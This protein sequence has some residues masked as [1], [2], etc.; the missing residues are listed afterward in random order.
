MEIKK[1]MQ[2]MYQKNV[3]KKKHF[4][5]LLM[6]EERK[7]HYVLVKDF[8]IFMYDYTLH[9]GIKDFCRYCLQA[10]SSEEILKRDNKD[11]FKVNGK[12]R[13]VMS[14]KDEYIK[15][16]NYE[17]KIKS[18]AIIHADF[19]SILVPEDNG[20]QNPEESYT[21][22]H[23]KHIACMYVNFSKVFKA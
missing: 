13:I 5:L 16:N 17:R 7:S 6:R 12:Q 19:E 22:K 8:N 1:N 10:F 2:S 14:K 3:V 15:V 20:K 11:C 18:T 4:D 23:Q 9:H 21:N